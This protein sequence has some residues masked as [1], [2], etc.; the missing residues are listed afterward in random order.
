MKRIFLISSLVAAVIASPAQ[1]QTGD[2]LKD[3][4]CKRD[5]M[6]AA[7]IAKQNEESA[8]SP[9]ARQQWLAYR[10]RLLQVST[11]ALQFNPTELDRLGCPK[12]PITIRGA[13]TISRFKANPSYPLCVGSGGYND[14]AEGSNVV[15]RDSSG[16]IVGASK[17]DFGMAVGSVCRFEFA[18][19]NIPESSFYSVEVGRRGALTYSQDQLKANGWR[20]DA[21][22]GGS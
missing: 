17:L 7:A 8:P 10:T 14:I 16:Q 3:S 9:Q 20:V 11:G 1:A 13:L 21:V 6:T 12:P 4:L 2:P 22:L 19:T 5:W 18:V 15:I